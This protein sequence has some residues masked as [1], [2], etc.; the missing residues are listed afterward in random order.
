MYRIAFSFYLVLTFGVSTLAQDAADELLGG[1]S[2]PET[3]AEQPATPP[4]A[5]DTATEPDAPNDA[6]DATD[7][8]EEGA[9]DEEAGDESAS[10]EGSSIFDWLDDLTSA[11]AL[12]LVRRGGVFMWPILLMAI[13]AMGVLIERYRS[14]K[15][16]NTDTSTLRH[17][18][19][20]L[21]EADRVEDALQLYNEGMK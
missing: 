8:A 19:H 2:E 6:N 12:G 11:G 20:Q 14:L 15:M 5:D 10:T 9:T 3:P 18:V 17:Q 7:A 13:I 4:P 21:L 1:D 16:L